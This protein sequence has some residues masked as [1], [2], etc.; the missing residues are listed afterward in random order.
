MIKS[1]QV[2]GIQ[3]VSIA[4][5]N[6]EKFQDLFSKDFR[7]N[8]QRISGN[9]S[10]FTWNIDNEEKEVREYIILTVWP[11]GI[12]EDRER[13]YRRCF[14]ELGKEYEDIVIDADLRF[15]KDMEGPK[16]ELEKLPVS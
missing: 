10:L 12:G 4:A 5:K 2:I 3:R 13:V 11:S 16:E 9:E 6:V 7:Y 1:T 15:T 8:L 14:E